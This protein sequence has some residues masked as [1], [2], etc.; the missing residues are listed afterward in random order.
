MTDRAGG[1]F[2][3]TKEEALEIVRKLLAQA[4]DPGVT[5][6]EAATFTGKAQQ[7]M[8]KYSIDLA[9]VATDRPDR[10]VQEGWKLSNPYATH[11]VALVNAVSRAN[12]CR[13]VFSPLQGGAKWIEVVGYPNDVEWVQTLYRS[14]DIQMAAALAAGRRLK[15]R[16]VHGRTFAAGFVQG[17]VDEV[18]A[19]LHRAR[20]EAVAHAEA[21]RE[22][23]RYEAAA[24]GFGAGA[25]GGDDPGQALVSVALVLVAKNTRVE[26]E[27]QVR[28]PGTTK[29]HRYSRLQSWSGYD[30][31]RAAGSRANLAR[32]SVPARRRLSA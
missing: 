15:P 14:L 16:D 9:L 1:A 32:G 24:A 11:K 5:P 10:V 29:V 23:E 27:F 21:E 20:R 22:R 2:R 6:D 7:M 18:G 17:F 12:D 26:E 30:P 3:R 25:R 19:R 28:F 4:E 13:A 31:G 8:T